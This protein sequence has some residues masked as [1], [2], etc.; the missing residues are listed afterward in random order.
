MAGI[1]FLGKH[2]V[3]FQSKCH[4]RIDYHH[5]MLSA[6]KMFGSVPFIH[7]CYWFNFFL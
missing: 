2:F 5:K 3:K 7:F 1:A 6:N 4:S